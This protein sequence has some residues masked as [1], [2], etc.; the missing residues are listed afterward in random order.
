MIIDMLNNNPICGFPSNW[1]GSN[2]S[3]DFGIITRIKN[4]FNPKKDSLI[5]CGCFGW[6]TK[7]CVDMLLD[8]DN[9]KI[10]SENDYFQIL[11][12]CDIDNKG[13]AHRKRL[14]IETLH[15]ITYKDEDL[16]ID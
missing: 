8:D 16:W 5:V 7:L 10:L 3:K 9:L 2:P 1:S 14:M 4:P 15:N 11:C 13:S 6:G 12:V